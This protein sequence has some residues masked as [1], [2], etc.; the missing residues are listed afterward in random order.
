M[1]LVFGF[2]GKKI[3]VGSEMCLD[4]GFGFWVCRVLRCCAEKVKGQLASVVVVGKLGG[5]IPESGESPLEERKTIFTLRA[6]LTV[7][8]NINGL[9]FKKIYSRAIERRKLYLQVTR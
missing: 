5:I 9:D 4:L 3:G 7:R 1:R 6:I 8:S 2:V